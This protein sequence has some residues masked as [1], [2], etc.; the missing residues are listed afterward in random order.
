MDCTIHEEKST[1]CAVTA[2]LICAFV[3]VYAK[4][5]F[6]HDAAQLLTCGQFP[7]LLS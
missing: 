2:Q 1:C 7:Q 6:P 5:R 4:S 3:L